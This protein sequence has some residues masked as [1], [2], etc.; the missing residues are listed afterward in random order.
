MEFIKSFWVVRAYRYA[1]ASFWFIPSVLTVVSLVVATFIVDTELS[2][3]RPLHEATGISRAMSLESARLVVSTIAGSM[4]TV[5]SLV[6]SMTLVALTMISQQLGPRILQRFMDDRPT[7]IVLGL[8]V[9]TFVFALI[10]LTRMDQSGGRVPG[11]AIISTVVL[12]VISLGGV[13]HF[14]HHIATRIQADVIIAELGCGLNQAT[15]NAF[16]GASF[17]GEIE[18]IC[19]SS[20]E[21]D[22]LF[23]T[24]GRATRFAVPAMSTGYI[25]DIDEISLSKLAEDHD[26]IVRI[27]SRPG[28][29]ILKGLPT[30]TVLMPKDE[31]GEDA[32]KKFNQLISVDAM[33]TSDATLEFDLNALVEI[34]LRA[35]S[36]GVNDPFTAMTCLDR[37]ADAL[38]ILLD[39]PQGRQV[40]HRN[41]EP[42][43]IYRDVTLD[44]YLGVT[45]HPIRM[46]ASNDSLVLM[47]LTELVGN[48][49]SLARE[50]DHR[51]ALSAHLTAIEETVAQSE[52][53]ETDRS[54]VRAEVTRARQ[55]RLNA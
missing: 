23:E 10:V 17:T 7:Q 49:L 25:N 26:V 34:A 38:R 15:Q 42:R 14:I 51:T 20:D 18:K 48:L 9:A 41:G 16:D 45:L 13:I 27:E 39:M 11:L 21:V 8:F 52:M 3:D 22:Q 54:A 55:S 6:F 19:L 12:A 43:I 32:R 29:F 5:V 30:M 31:I 4:I 36:P 28:T 24:S 33:R 37:L 44:H 2:L 40:L 47:K 35:L 46:A 53:I 1:R 50:A